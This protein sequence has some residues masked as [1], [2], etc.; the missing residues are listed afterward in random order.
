MQLLICYFTIRL[1]PK[2]HKTAPN[3]FHSIKQP[4]N[5]FHAEKPSLDTFTFKGGPIFWRNTSQLTKN[6]CFAW[7]F[8]YSS[9]E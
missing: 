9:R 4:N 3:K 6:A 8:N 2:K 7:K 5:N 1:L